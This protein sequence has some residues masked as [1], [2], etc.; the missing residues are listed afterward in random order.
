M[1]HSL[2]LHLISLCFLP[3]FSSAQSNWTI[4]DMVH[5]NP[6]EA[7]TQTEFNSPDTLRSYGYN[8]KEFF[9]SRTGKKL[10]AEAVA[11]MLK[12]AAKAVGVS[13][14]IRVSPHTCRH[15]FAHLNLK[16]GIDRLFPGFCV[17][18]IVA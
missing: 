5:N 17:N 18:A 13:E 15:T 16:N 6:G 2:R 7:P 8:D 4:M 11:K 10:T 12:K 14:D 1:N 9:L 3:L